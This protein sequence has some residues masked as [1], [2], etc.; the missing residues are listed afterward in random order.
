MS[1]KRTKR[2]PEPAITIFVAT[3]VRR[4]ER[5]EAETNVV[6]T[7]DNLSFG[8]ALGSLRVAWVSG[9]VAHLTMSGSWR[10][11]V[12]GEAGQR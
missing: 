8:V 11:H 1:T 6:A 7:S 9:V 2:M 4:A 10:G 3:V 5:A 12:S